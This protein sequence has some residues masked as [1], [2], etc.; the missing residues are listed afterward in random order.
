MA[1]MKA[2]VAMVLAAGKGRRIGGSRKQFMVVAG[3]P[4]FLHCLHVLKKCSSIREIVVVVPR[5]WISRVQNMIPLNIRP[6]IHVI[7]G[8]RSRRASTFAGLKFIRSRNSF[9]DVVVVHDAVRPLI[10]CKDVEAVIAAARKNGG[11]LLAMPTIDTIG[12]VAGGYIRSIPDR[13]KLFTT[14]TPHAYRLSLL[15]D[16]HCSSKNR[17][18]KIRYDENSALVAAIGGTIKVVRGSYPNVKLTYQEDLL[19]IKALLR[20]H[21]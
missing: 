5:D 21:L 10:H 18:K 20:Q 4:L 17:A 6:H 13:K 16:A 7:A 2:A 8:G 14:F 9:P 11:A 12:E 15:W 1:S 19:V 3:K